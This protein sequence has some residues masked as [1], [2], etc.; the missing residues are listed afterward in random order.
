[1]SIGPDAPLDELEPYIRSRLHPIETY[2]AA[3]M[4]ARTG[5]YEIDPALMQTPHAPLK[6]AA[7]LAALVTRP[8]GLS[9][10][11]TRRSDTLARHSGQVAFPGGR[12]EPGEQPWETALREAE[13]EIG[14]DPSL[15]RLVGIGDLY[16]TGTGYLITPVVGFLEPGFAL[17][18]HPGEVAEVF[19]TPF[20]F[21][22]N[23]D[24]HERRVWHD[25]SGLERRYYAMP[26]EGPLIWG[27]TAGMVRRLYER[28]FSQSP[29][30]G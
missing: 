19:E 4:Q 12:A 24:N 21:L 30:P 27:V 7:V 9:V 22:M 3:A 26:H 17:K 16:A 28:L 25:A 23:P 11:L 6:P 20:A 10:L 29:G 2:D 18:P 1:M 15:V 14:L 5:D 8:E 13:E